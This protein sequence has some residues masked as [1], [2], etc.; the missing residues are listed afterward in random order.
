[1]L[2]TWR[3]LDLVP[4]SVLRRLHLD[5]FARVI[6]RLRGGLRGIRTV[7]LSVHAQAKQGT[8]TFDAAGGH[9]VLAGAGTS[10][11]HLVLPLYVGDRIVHWGL[12]LE[13]VGAAGIRVEL[14]RFRRSAPGYEVPSLH[15][16]TS[17]PRV[18]STRE[19]ML[20]VGM[21]PHVVEEGWIYRLV[22]TAG[23]A[24]DKIYGGWL[25]VDH[26]RVG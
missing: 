23:N 16:Q 4:G 18:L 10:E 3:S 1:M 17:T 9:A 11:I 21:A 7:P 14:R 12:C 2:P 20:A 6:D 15:V 13:R 25:H 22:V 5:H 26:P 19:T 24:G 8:V